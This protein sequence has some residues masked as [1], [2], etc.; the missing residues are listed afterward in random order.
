MVLI[1]A[2]VA[3][4]IAVAMVMIV[5]VASVVTPALLSGLD[6]KETD[7]QVRLTFLVDKICQ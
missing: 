6:V 7:G 3:I 2:V 4:A 1:I 5:V